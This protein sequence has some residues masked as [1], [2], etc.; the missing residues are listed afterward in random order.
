MPEPAPKATGFFTPQRLAFGQ[1]LTICVCNGFASGLPL[2]VLYSLIQPWMNREGVDIEKIGWLVTA[3]VAPYAWKFAWAPLVDRYFVANIGRRRS[4]AFLTQI[5]LIVLIAVL[6]SFDPVRD[7]QSVLWVCVGIGIAS[8]TQDIALDAWRRELLPDNELGLGTSFWVN[9]YRLA[10]LVP[11]S[12]ALILFGIG[13]S[14]ASIF[15]IVAVFM[16]VG[17]LVTIFAAEPHSQ[18]PPED[19]KQAIIGP[20]VEFFSERKRETA[21]GAS[22]AI[23]FVLLYK[24]GDQ[25]ATALI[26]PFYQ[27]IGFSE[28]QIGSVAKLI[29]FWSLIAGGLIGGIVMVRTGINRGLWIFGVLQMVTILGFVWLSATEIAVWKLALAVAGE[30]F[31]AGLGTTALTAFMLREV[32]TRYSATQ[33]A[34]LTSLFGMTRAITSGIAGELIARFG[35]YE[36]FWICF[37]LAIPGML[38]LFLVAP[39]NEKN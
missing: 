38:V 21:F 8:A 25:L 24:L 32:S 1:R 26:T 39:W 17:L 7:Y 27:D 12:L 20:F 22:A 29:G 5:I 34:L 9:A 18:D 33:L 14:W 16:L 10:Q 31:A 30:N 4:W 6:G 23:A 28:L 11:G 15:P 3:A 35:Y 37:A 13:Y 2:W 36:F 19:L